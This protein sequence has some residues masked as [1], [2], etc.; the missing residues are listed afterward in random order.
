[1][2]I[3][4]SPHSDRL[5]VA[6]LPSSPS[7]SSVV[8]I[9]KISSKSISKPKRRKSVQ[10]SFPLVS[11]TFDLSPPIDNP[12]EEPTR[13]QL[14]VILREQ[15]GPCIQQTSAFLAV[16]SQNKVPTKKASAVA[17]TEAHD[18]FL[19][20]DMFLFSDTLVRWFAHHESDI[21]GNDCI[22]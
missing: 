1:M 18:I 13:T 3:Q 7:V 6:E 10:F 4:C 17:R 5:V 14:A 2:T 11:G 9:A 21:K 16:S 12:C 22:C 19:L 15:E 8:D 20:R